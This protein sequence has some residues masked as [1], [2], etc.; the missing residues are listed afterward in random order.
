MVRNGQ[1]KS[2]EDL[3][4][5]LKL[6]EIV[7]L[8]NESFTSFIKIK[9]NV[10]YTCVGK[11]NCS[12]LVYQGLDCNHVDQIKW[13]L[14]RELREHELIYGKSWARVQFRQQTNT[15]DKNKNL[16]I[17]SQMIITDIGVIHNGNYI[18]SHDSVGNQAFSVRVRGNTEII[19]SVSKLDSQMFVLVLVYYRNGTVRDRRRKMLN[20]Y[21]DR[22][23]SGRTWQD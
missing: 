19:N 3:K 9:S 15:F 14:P 11:I 18:C 13:L 10:L 1:A 20:L 21:W 4:D 17:E 6:G 12:E 23:R 8:T 5:E 22:P 2:V 7:M 16:M